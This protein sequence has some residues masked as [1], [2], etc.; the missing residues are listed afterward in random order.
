[1]PNSFVAEARTSTSVP[2]VNSNGDALRTLIA[3]KHSVALSI[4]LSS[5][6]HVVV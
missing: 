5:P 3:T 1:M 6:L 2:F 4:E